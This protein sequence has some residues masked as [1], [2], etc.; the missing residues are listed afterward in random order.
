MSFFDGWQEF[1]V[2]GASVPFYKFSENGISYVGFD[3]RKCMPPEPML[4]AM[5]ALKLFGKESKVVMVN[6]KFPAGLIPK[7]ES[8]FDVE[9]ENLSGEEVKLT[10]SLKD[11]VDIS[12]FDFTQTCHG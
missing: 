8:S 4:N 6:H 12:S 3:S 10:F 5:L 7:I 1:L 2:D 9:R 11:G